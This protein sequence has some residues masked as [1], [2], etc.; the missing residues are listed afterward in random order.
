MTR[1][2]SQAERKTR[3]RSQCTS[4]RSAGPTSS[5]QQSLTCS[6]SAEAGSC[7]SPLTDEVHEVLELAVVE[8]A[9]DEAELA[10]GL[11]AALGEVALV[12]GEAQLSVLEDEVLS[13]VVVAA[14][15]SVHGEGRSMCSGGRPW[16]TA[17]PS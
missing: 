1:W 11:L 13:G 14:C 10:R 2:S 9:A 8:R 4:E 3:R 5:G 16:R 15:L 6:P 17:E 12:E 7:T